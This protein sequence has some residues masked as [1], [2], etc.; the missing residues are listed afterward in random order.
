MGEPVD[1]PIVG[2]PCPG[3]VERTCKP[4]N[5]CQYEGSVY[6]PGATWSKA[7][8]ACTTCYCHEN[9]QG[10]FVSSCETECCGPCAV[11]G[12]VRVQAHADQCCGACVPVSCTDS[13]GK[14][15]AINDSWQIGE[16]ECVLRTCKQ[17][18]RE[19][20]AECVNTC[21]APE[22]E[23]LVGGCALANDY[24]GRVTVEIKGQLCTSDRDYTVNMCSGECVSS[25]VNIDG[26]MQKQ[27]SCCSA[28]KTENK[29]IVVECADGS[30][31]THMFEFVEECSCGVTKCEE[32]PVELVEPEVIQ[33]VKRPSPPVARP[34]PKP[35]QKKK[36]KKKGLWGKA[37]DAVGSF[38]G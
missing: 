12:H 15:R 10:L 9:E 38:L 32:A 27:C 7:G 23:P 17:G 14:E 21:L 26:K 35:Q 4:L 5:F 11:P 19:L 13:E 33:P 3:H 29:E 24:S 1:T 28:V 6:Q 30:V 2:G 22:R 16:D 8:D 20:Y 31:H 36:K 18:K 37:E 25:T 34:Q